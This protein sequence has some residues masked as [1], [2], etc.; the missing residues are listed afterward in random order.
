MRAWLIDSRA[1]WWSSAGSAAVLAAALA[2]PVSAQAASPAFSLAPASP[3]LAGIG[4]AQGDILSPAL[5]PAPGSLPPP[6]VSIPA[7]VLGIAPGDVV[8]D[9]SFGI[10]P[11]VPVAGTRVLFSVDA[12]AIGVPSVPPPATLSCEAGQAAADVFVANAYGL[13]TVPPAV[14]A[15]D[16]NGLA[17]STCGPPASPGLG[18]IEPGD[19][20]TGL[21]MCPASFILSGGVL[22]GPVYFTLAAGSPTLT[23]LG[24]T[25]GDVLVQVPPGSGPPAIFMAAAGPALGLVGGAPGCGAPACDEIDALEVLPTGPYA[26][27]S[28][29]PGSPSLALCGATPGDLLAAGG[30]GG[31]LVL[32]GAGALGLG[33]LDNTDAIAVNVDTDGDLIADL[34]DNCPAV[35]NSDQTDTNSNGHGDACEA[36]ALCPLTPGSCASAGASA[37]YLKDPGMDGGG[38]PGDKMLWKWL[39]GPATEQADFGDPTATADYSICLYDGAG[40]F[41][42]SNLSATDPRWSALGDKG[43]QYKSSEVGFGVSKLQLKGG[44]AGRAKIQLKSKYGGGWSGSALPLDE[45]GNVVVQVHNSDNSNCW[46]SVFPPSSVQGNTETSFKAKAQ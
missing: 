5:P 26:L 6:V 41:M 27:F 11:P 3:S 40:L 13:P 8:R 17:D 18:L 7:A 4:A 28:L 19:N 14:L 1:S 36:Q 16:G 46:Q 24:A 38:D 31:C 34:C 25:A 20:I 22:L 35:A 21:E 39:R 44:S 29:A 43:Y 33:A 32:T 37:L 15:L 12:A 23:A 30:L 45:T 9:F 2:L 42:E 10:L